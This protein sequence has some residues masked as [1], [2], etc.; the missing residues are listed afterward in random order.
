LMTEAAKMNLL[1]SE[2]AWLLMDDNSPALLEAVEELDNNQLLDGV[3]LFDMKMSLY[4]YQPFEAFLDEWMKLD[5]R[6]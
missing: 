2:Y 1:S 6:V 4:G 5:P 3:F